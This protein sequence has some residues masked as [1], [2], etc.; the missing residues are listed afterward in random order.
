MNDNNYYIEVQCMLRLIFP[1][2]FMRSR[3]SRAQ[4]TRQWWGNQRS[5]MTDEKA[6]EREVNS[7]LK[8]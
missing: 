6:S 3:E 1:T 2:F 7:K 4:A 5:E 8:L